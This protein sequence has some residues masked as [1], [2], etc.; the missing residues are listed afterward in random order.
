[1]LSVPASCRTL[2]LQG[3]DLDVQR[4]RHSLNGSQG[5][6]RSN[7]VQ[8][9]QEPHARQAGE[10]RLQEIHAFGGDFLGEKR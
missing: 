10:R 2:H 8:V 1:M 6:G 5:A 7:I 4:L 3:L 9:G